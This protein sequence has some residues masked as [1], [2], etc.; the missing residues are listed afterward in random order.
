MKI[1]VNIF[2][3]L[4]ISFYLHG[5]ATVAGKPTHSIPII[6]TPSG[7]SVIIRD[8]NGTEVFNGQ[9]PVIVNLNKSDG[10]YFGGK[11]YLVTISKPGFKTLIYPVLPTLNDYYLYGNLI[12]SYI[13]WF[14][15]DPFS[16]KMY[17]L[18]PET[19]NIPLQ[20]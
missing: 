10:S 14:L 15:V 6:T 16:G 4:L 12:N 1:L 7:A 3:V 20:E 19:I 8:E 11:S 2:S 9:T 5:C 18:S 17:D 13:G